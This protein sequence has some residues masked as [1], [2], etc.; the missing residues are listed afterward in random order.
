MSREWFVDH[1][2]K[3]LGPFRTKQLKRL[4][5]TG[6]INS[7]TRIRIGSAGKWVRAA[8]VRGLFKS[9][10]D[11][12]WNESES[13]PLP[14]LPVEPPPAPWE[15]KSNVADDQ[16]ASVLGD[17]NAP[18]EAE[19][20]E[21]F[22]ASQSVETD[23]KSCPYCGEQILS[24]AIKCRYCGEFLNAQINV[25]RHSAG[26][27]ENWNPGVAAVLSVVIPGLGQVYKQQILN[28]FV[29]FIAVLLGYAFFVIP[30]IV[31]HIACVFGAASGD[32][33]RSPSSSTS[34][35]T[36]IIAG[37]FIVGLIV[38]GIVGFFVDPPDTSRRSD[39]TTTAKV[40]APEVQR[41][42]L[43]SWNWHLSPGGQYVQVEG[44]ITNV[45][46]SPFD[47]VKAVA[48]FFDSE[49]GFITSDSAYIEY[50]PLLPGQTSPFSVM[51]KHNPRMESASIEFAKPFG[52]VIPTVSKETNADED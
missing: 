40:P 48:S 32:K 1:K 13:Q 36:S 25:K 7:E 37:V 6:Q 2:G 22:P 16:I 5:E 29:W 52:N 11:Q 26:R 3:T 47:G 46:S 41:L 20:F 51:V 9:E 14:A 12:T 30:G 34:S 38:C 45:S 44:Q 39:P 23:Y 42:Q 19:S 4:A 43:E 15:A 33:S 18:A 49:G 24:T 28:G 35:A 21:H 10:L 17:F 31:L 27:Q 8:S 50:R